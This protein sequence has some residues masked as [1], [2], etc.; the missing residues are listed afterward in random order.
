MHHEFTACVYATVCILY[1]TVR[2]VSKPFEEEPFEWRMYMSMM[3]VIMLYQILR[4]S[5]K[6]NDVYMY[7]CM[8]WA[9]YVLCGGTKYPYWMAAY[10]AYVTVVH[11]LER[12]E[13]RLGELE[14]AA[15]EHELYVVNGHNTNVDQLTLI[16]MTVEQLKQAQT[17]HE[18]RYLRAQDEEPVGLSAE[19]N[20][21]WKMSDNTGMMYDRESRWWIVMTP[22]V[23]MLFLYVVWWDILTW[24]IAL[25]AC[26][27]MALLSQHCKIRFIVYH[28]TFLFALLY[29]RY[30]VFNA[31]LKKV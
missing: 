10:G 17:M 18:F 22:F 7:M 26:M 19:E 4:V 25:D 27:L 14:D 31:T 5:W 6:L 13:R 15:M 11:I 20:I 8:Q 2:D 29:A 30:D 23:T 16:P 1:V 3:G 28:I 12:G 24:Y 9:T 21:L